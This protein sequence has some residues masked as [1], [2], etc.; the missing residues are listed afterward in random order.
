MLVR[1]YHR[2]DARY[3]LLLR[4]VAAWVRSEVSFGHTRQHVRGARLFIEVRNAYT[5]VFFVVGTIVLLLLRRPRSLCQILDALLH[6]LLQL[7]AELEDGGLVWIYLLLDQSPLLS[8]AGSENA[9]HLPAYVHV[10][11]CEYVQLNTVPLLS[12]LTLHQSLVSL[13]AGI[14]CL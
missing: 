3:S 1:V 2:L 11:L 5:A 7:V 9:P 12:V 6:A 14:G 13:A 4:R 10:C 8:N